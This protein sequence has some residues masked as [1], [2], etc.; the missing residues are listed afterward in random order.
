MTEYYRKMGVGDCR[1]SRLRLRCFL[2]SYQ[3]SDG[4]VDNR[5]IF[6]EF[7]ID[8]QGHRNSCQ[9]H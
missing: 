5:N 9:G 2:L 1:D 6:M 3:W 4:I 8:P 7:P